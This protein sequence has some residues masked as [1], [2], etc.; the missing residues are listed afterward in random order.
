M[1]DAIEQGEKKPVSWTRFI[2]LLFIGAG[3]VAVFATGAY[4]YLSLTAL[5]ENYLTLETFVSENFLLAATTY[6]AIYATAVLLSLPG[7][8]VL[9]IFGGVL[10][11]IAFGVPLAL[12]GA[13]IGASGIFLIA[14][15][16]LGELLEK[17]AAR[18]VGPMQKG[19]N[20]NAF[21]YLLLLRLVPAFPFFVINIVP[22]FLGVKFRTYF[23]ATVIGILPGNF[24]Y[25]SAGNGVRY[26]IKNGGDVSIGG[27]LTEPQILIPIVALCL[28]AVIPIALKAFG[29]K[30]EAEADAA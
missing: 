23:I 13:M 20:E 16:S 12:T 11:G 25:V 9:T 27:L 21:S 19:F 26:T 4:K 29:K 8:G 3:V 6:V 5:Q 17:S 1:T 30:P 28:L 2:P 15:T 18:Y 14:K 10:F 24:A 22:A 7:A